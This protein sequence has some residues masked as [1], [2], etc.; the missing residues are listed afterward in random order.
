MIKTFKK[1]V[2]HPRKEKVTIYTLTDKGKIFCEILFD[3]TD[4]LKVIR[5]NKKILRNILK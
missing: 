2:E 3:D 4:F 5:Q 1:E